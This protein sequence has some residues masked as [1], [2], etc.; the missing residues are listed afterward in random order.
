MGAIVPAAVAPLPRQARQSAGLRRR[1][2]VFYSGMAFAVA[3]LVVVGFSPTFFLRSYFGGPELT[4]LRIA[5]GS[6]FTAWVA[7]FVVQT[8]LVA[9]RRTP[10]HR[11]LG[12]A[13]AVLAVAMVGLGVALAISAARAGRAPPGQEPRAF[14]A[15]PLFDLATFAPLV[16]A[17]IWFRGRP[18]THKRLMLLATL[19]ILGAAAG[20]LPP[21]AVYGPLF[22]FGVVDVLVLAG[23]V[24]DL[25]T[26]RRVHP[27]YVWG[28]LL[29]ILSQPLRL[30]LSGTAAWLAFA[31]MLIGR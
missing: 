5:H 22:F 15:I 2:H 14:L 8:L 9:T 25:A 12:V 24:Y 28:G 4:P 16:A 19:S 21:A 26:R 1:D 11:R 31:G 13:G 29:I 30:V 18:E 10:V 3:A 7:L 23:P 17:A 20:R 27:A 6:A